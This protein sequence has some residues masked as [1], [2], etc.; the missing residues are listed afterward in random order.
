VTAGLDCAFAS[1]SARLKST[2][3]Q[4]VVCII[5]LVK[6]TLL[7]QSLPLVF[8]EHVR[9]FSL[10]RLVAVCFR[11]VHLQGLSVQL[12]PAHLLDRVERRLLA[13]K[14]DERLALALQAALRN[15]IQNRAV[16]LEDLCE[17]LLHRVDLDTLLEIVDLLQSASRH[18]V[19]CECVPRS[20][21]SSR[22]YY[23]CG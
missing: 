22:I 17:R 11:P 18:R 8:V 20:A 19:Q 13:V 23:T 16:V 9:R 6:R 14:H 10:H 7:H 3:D 21:I 2:D 15:N 12:K 5:A 4:P 1:S